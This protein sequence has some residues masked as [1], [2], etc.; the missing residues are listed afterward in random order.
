[1]KCSRVNTLLALHVG[2]DLDEAR[3]ARVDLHLE[4]CESCSAEA[5]AYEASR[6]SLFALKG[7]TL[8]PAPDLW[9]GVRLRLG[10]PPRIRRWSP[11]RVAAALLVAATG[12]FAV[13]SALPG[14]D[15][16]E[17]G[18]TPPVAEA[19]MKVEKPAD[20][21]PDRF[22]LAEVGPSS[23]GP[24]S[25]LTKHLMSSRNRAFHSAHR[26]HDGKVPTW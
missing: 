20:F 3:A 25:P 14:E 26:P 18:T 15:R 21:G 1:M 12:T 24:E 16:P 19:E 9:P 4:D 2:G 17:T 10:P 8:P 6:Q 11:L 5:A 7:D 23:P 13:F 22:M